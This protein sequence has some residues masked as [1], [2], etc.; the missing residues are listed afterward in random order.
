MCPLKREQATRVSYSTSTHSRL[1][2][3][4]REKSRSW[5]KCTL[6]VNRLSSLERAVRLSDDRRLSTNHGV[7]RSLQSSHW[8]NKTRSCRST[9]APW[10]SV[11][12]EFFCTW[13]ERD[14]QHVPVGGGDPVGVQVCMDPHFWVPCCYRPTWPIV[15]VLYG[16]WLNSACTLISVHGSTLN[17]NVDCCL[18]A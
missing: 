10:R 3:R 1:Y 13:C 17:I 2:C 15:S 12:R 6:N 9:D 16:Q 11:K 5:I 4:D 7:L 18:T 8:R 14:A